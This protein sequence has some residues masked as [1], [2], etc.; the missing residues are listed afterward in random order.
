M[1]SSLPANVHLSFSARKPGRPDG[2]ADPSAY[3]SLIGTPG[4]IRGSLYLESLPG[5][6]R[7]FRQSFL[8]TGS[9]RCPGNA[10][11]GLPAA[12]TLRCCGLTATSFFLRDNC[13]NCHSRESVAWLSSVHGAPVK[14]KGSGQLSGRSPAAR[15]HGWLPLLASCPS[16][17]SACSAFSSYFCFYRLLLIA[18]PRIVI[19]SAVLLSTLVLACLMAALHHIVATSLKITKTS[20]GGWLCLVF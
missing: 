14:W 8:F 6:P 16:S 15:T 1:R 4:A 3:T 7:C 9:L 19:L 5:R 10:P 18:T 12:G 20:I 17:C 11:R 2:Q 13:A